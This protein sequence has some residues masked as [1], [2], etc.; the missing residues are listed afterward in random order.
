[1]PIRVLFLLLLF[2][3]TSRSIAQKLPNKQETSVWLPVNT[4]I[5]GKA[6]EWNNQ[7]Q[8]YNN[9]TGIFYTI[10]D[11]DENL[12]L[13]V[14]ANDPTII[15]KIIKGGVTFTVNGLNKKKDKNDISVTFP[16]YDKKATPL[17]LILNNK[18]K[19]TKDTIRNKVQADSFM[20][21]R[22]KQLTDK[23]KIIGAQG[24]K[25]IGDSIISIYNDEGNKSNVAS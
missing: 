20:N 21:A 13:A 1:M 4:N 3:A 8:A 7:F 16:M 23:F 15:Q 11:D 19:E 12:Y 6:T 10:A 25:A 18:P 5:D 22:N 14:Q 2:A 9:A 24:I 17:F